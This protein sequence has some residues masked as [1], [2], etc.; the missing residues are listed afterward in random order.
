MRLQR[1]LTAA[2]TFGGMIGLAAL[3]GAIEWRTSIF[4]PV[5]ILLASG[6][7]WS[8]ACRKGEWDD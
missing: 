6:A 8:A 4:W 5:V 2:G 3:C 7:C 1:I